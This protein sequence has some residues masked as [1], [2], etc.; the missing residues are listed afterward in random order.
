[1][2]NDLLPGFDAQRKARFDEL[3]CKP[4]QRDKQQ[5]LTKLRGVLLDVDIEP[6][7]VAHDECGVGQ[8]R[9]QLLGQVVGLVGQHV[10]VS[11][12]ARTT[13]KAGEG[14][15]QRAGKTSD[16]SNWLNKGSF[17]LFRA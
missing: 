9:L 11:R 12:D 10:A 13:A 2:L 17:L 16:H 3:C 4:N 1:M 6:V 15:K 8:L 7:G 14:L 5:T